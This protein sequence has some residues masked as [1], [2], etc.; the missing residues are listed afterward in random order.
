MELVEAAFEDVRAR[1][2]ATVD[3][4]RAF[5][6]QALSLLGTC[7]TLAVGCASGVAVGLAP[8]TIIPGAASSALAGACCSLVVGSIFCVGV[9]SSTPLSLPGRE[10]EFWRLALVQ[11]ARSKSDILSEFL[12][13]SE[14]S[15]NENCSLIE[16]LSH[17]MKRARGALLLSPIA[18]ATSAAAFIY[19]QRVANL[20]GS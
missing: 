19:I 18:A 7:S 8:D 15:I 6:A 1:H 5:E 11:T 17:K 10:V 4:V 12:R 3:H 13:V 20:C 2:S 16:K 9:L 14:V